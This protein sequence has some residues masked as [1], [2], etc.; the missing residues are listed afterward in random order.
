[1]SRRIRKSVKRVGQKIQNFIAM[2]QI[3]YWN[4]VALEANRIS[5]TEGGE[6]HKG[7]NGPTLSS[8]ALAILHL[9]MYDATIGTSPG[10]PLS[11]YL[12]AATPADAG[13]SRD[14]A[15]ATA[16]HAILSKLY[17]KLKAKINEAHAAAGLAQANY[18]KGFNFGMRVATEIW[19]TR[20]DDPS[21]SD[22]GYSTTFGV[23]RHR[24][25]PNNPQPNNAPFYG[26]NSQTFAVTKR[27]GIKPPPQVGT[28]DYK[29]ALRQVRSKGIIPRQMGTLPANFSKRTP[30]ETLIGI[31]W[32]YDGAKNLGT[33]PRF[34]NQIVRQIALTK[35]NPTT[36]AINDVVQN[37]YLFALVNTA[38]GDA[39]ILA[40]E[41]K[42]KH[43]FWR[44]ILGVREHDPS[45]GVTGV[46][47]NVWDNDC[48]PCWLPLG[49]PN[50]NKI[51]ENNFTP[52]FPAYPSGHATFGAASLH[53]TR[54]FYGEPI[55]SF[56]PDIINTFKDMA[57]VSDEFNGINSDSDG[58]IR[59]KHH[60]QFKDGL[61]QM[62]FENGLSRVFLGV[63]WFFDAFDLKANALNGNAA[64]RN[65][66][67]DELDISVNTATPNEVGIGGVPLGLAIAEDL[68]S[69][70]LSPVNTLP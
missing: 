12:V 24:Q 27:W 13:A 1:M 23:G 54:L 35:P 70:G 11:P 53:I 49:A 19:K 39:G 66:E 65:V 18:D 57:F 48:D 8:R 40:W 41:Q 4:G 67:I 64:A 25:D 42:Y 30:E 52:P 46:G 9:A 44:P 60:R 50:T 6:K 47:G 29:R 15:I 5:H 3:I 33:P 16:A 37:A 28:N 68:F 61:W 51:G 69:N 38:M 2:D 45:M 20:K 62:I 32:G 58:T 63:H 14:V 43:N 21:D 31:Y 34:F 22:D 36:G 59:P 10:T 17:P 26:A 55:G 56:V 7:V